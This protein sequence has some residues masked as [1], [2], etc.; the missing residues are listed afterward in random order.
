MHASVE[1]EDGRYFHKSLTQLDQVSFVRDRTGLLEEVEEED[2]GVESGS[3]V[4]NRNTPSRAESEGPEEDYASDEML[5]SPMNPAEKTQ[6]QLDIESE[7][8]LDRLAG[9]SDSRQTMQGQASTEP[10]RSA[11]S[12]RDKLTARSQMT[13]TTAERTISAFCHYARPSERYV[14][15]VNRAAHP[16][17]S[18]GV[19]TL[20]MEYD[21]D[22]VR[23][24]GLSKLMGDI[25]APRVLH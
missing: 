13:A 10:V 25:H 19:G 1:A 23:H 14:P 18:M 22:K 17:Q 15:H 20:A 12:N 7:W 11:G 24:L 16:K 6:H 4:A 3:E 9:T 5:Y 21:D 8:D 2:E